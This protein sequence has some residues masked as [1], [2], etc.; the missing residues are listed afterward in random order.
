MPNTETLVW[1]LGGALTVVSTLSGVIWTMVRSESAKQAEEIERKADT[2]RLLEAEQRWAHE[3]N[4]VREG[5]EKLVNKLEVRHD[6]E[7]EQITIR[8]GEQ[9]RNT[10]TNILTQI[11]LMI[12]AM[13]APRT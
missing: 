1:V 13:N 7:I 4:A 12:Q 10:E 3:L 11:R 2:S 6:R 8:L 5:S 9:I